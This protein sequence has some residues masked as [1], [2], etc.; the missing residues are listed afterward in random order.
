MIKILYLCIKTSIIT[1][2]IK[3]NLVILIYSS[4]KYNYINIYYGHIQM[5]NLLINLH[6]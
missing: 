6:K 4:D 2:N 1:K 5:L 3:Y